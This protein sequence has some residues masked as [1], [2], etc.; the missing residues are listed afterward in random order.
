MRRA[1][2]A[3][4]RELAQHWPNARRI[5]VICG[6]GNNGGDGAVLARLARASLRKVVVLRL[7]E[8]EP[9]TES[10]RQAFAGWEADGS[11]EPCQRSISGWMRC[12]ESASGARLK[13]L[14]SN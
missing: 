5:G 12:S 14:R 1:G 11:M 7:P 3:A 6:P 13:A 2:A 9:R 4:W 10:A 8:G